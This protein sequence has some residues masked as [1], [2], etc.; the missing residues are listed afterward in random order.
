[1]SLLKP[2]HEWPLTSYSERTRS[3]EDAESHMVELNDIAI[4]SSQD[5]QNFR[6]VF[7]DRCIAL[8][9]RHGLRDV[10]ERI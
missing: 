5:V 3:P 9:V 8:E 10:G 4:T 6:L 7:E 2:A 1:M